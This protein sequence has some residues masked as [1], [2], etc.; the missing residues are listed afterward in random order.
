MTNRQ[1]HLQHVKKREYHAGFFEHVGWRLIINRLTAALTQTSTDPATLFRGR[2]VIQ[3][4]ERD[5]GLAR[6]RWEIVI[7]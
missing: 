5:R 2:A 4:E 1:Y 3:G 6:G 7:P